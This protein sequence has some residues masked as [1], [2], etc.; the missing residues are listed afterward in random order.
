MASCE[1][2]NSSANPL[3]H[4]CA[5]KRSRCGAV[6]IPNA[7]CKPFRCS[8]RVPALPR[9]V[10]FEFGLESRTL[11]VGFRGRQR[12]R[13]EHTAM[14]LRCRRP[15]RQHLRMERSESTTL[16]MFWP[17]GGP[18][19]WSVQRISLG[20]NYLFAVSETTTFLLFWA[21]CGTG[22]WSVLRIPFGIDNPIAVLAGRRR[23]RG[24]HLQSIRVTGN[25]APTQAHPDVLRF[26]RYP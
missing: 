9:G 26:F 20:I 5:L 17:R 14:F 6:R 12:W 2:Q 3:Q 25:I 8:R 4:V 7:D 22:A 15:F 11:L 18:C 19:A 10:F 21:G 13:V 23:W 24:E 1:F 16:S